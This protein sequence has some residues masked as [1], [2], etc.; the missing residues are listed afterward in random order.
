MTSTVSICNMALANIAK[1]DEIQSLDE[2]SAEAKAC[3]RFY[4]QTLTAM[5]EAYPWRFAGKTAA[6][7]E[8]VNV[9]PKR[10]ARAYQRPS[11]CRKVRRLTD[12]LMLPDVDAVGVP[13]EI[14]GSTIFC[15][16]APAYLEYTAD[17]T[18]PTK[19][20][21]L[22]VEALS[23]QLAVKLAM[24]LTRD[25]KVRA[26]AYQLA[27]RTTVAAQIHDANEVRQS[28]DIVARYLPDATVGVRR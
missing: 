25:P 5:I 27:E 12:A 28:T 15:N 6:L 16:V 7:A 26:D 20:S 4:G 13:L 17:Q 21:G 22:F 24:P 9:K 23:W 14:E 1:P 2:D 8:I 10:W 11:D 18:D 19:F 3:K